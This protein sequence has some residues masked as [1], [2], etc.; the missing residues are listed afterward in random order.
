MKRKFGDWKCRYL[1]LAILLI[2]T[3]GCDFF[4][5]DNGDV[6]LFDRLVSYNELGTLT[7]DQI[8]NI[9]PSELSAFLAHDVVVYRVVYRTETPVGDQVQASGVVLAPN[10]SGA[11]RM[12]SLHRSTIFHELE[13]PSNVN[14][15]N[16]DQ[17]NMVWANFAPVMASA[18]FITVMPDLLGWGESSSLFHPYMITVSDEVVAYDMLLAAMDL[19]ED[20]EILWN[21]D[22][23]VT[24][25]SQ[26]ASTAMALLRGIEAD[27]S[28]RFEVKAAS[29]GGGAYNL[30]ALAETLLE[31]DELSFSPFYVYFLKAYRNTY[32]PDR[33][34]GSFL[35]SPY[36]NIIVND[37][38][39]R[40]GFFGN[41][42][43]ERLTHVTSDLLL[44]SFRNNFITSN[45]VSGQ[46]S[47]FRSI[48]SDNDLSSFRV[49]IPLRIYHGE[50]DEILPYSEA[51]QSAQNLEDAGSGNLEFITV[52]NGTHLSSVAVYLQETFF[53]FLEL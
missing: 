9:Y 2:L 26:G 3:A 20:A 21:N 44:N 33:T 30:E 4:E 22:L 49:E 45:T 28:G 1:L 12:V 41:E 14:L 11:S 13:A 16:P 53:W 29:V 8:S 35:N 7:S 50:D 42:I 25:Y 40:G 17:S 32:F 37:Q 43:A 24:G 19:T 15:N 6:V 47:E 10:R 34:L 31:Q 27:A 36:D 39:F 52:Q 46:E 18:G 23:F 51:L 38:L 48:L 5:E